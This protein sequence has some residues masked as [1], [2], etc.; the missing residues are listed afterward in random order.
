MIRPLRRT[1][2]VVVRKTNELCAAGT[3]GCLD[4][5]RRAAAPDGWVS[6][7]WSR[8]PGSMARHPRD[9]VAPL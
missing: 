9:N 6:A 3:K 4:L 8:F 7:E 2:V 5:R 1:Y